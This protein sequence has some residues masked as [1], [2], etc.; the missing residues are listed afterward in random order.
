MATFMVGGIMDGACEIHARLLVWPNESC[1]WMIR[2]LWI[3]GHLKLEV[4]RDNYSLV[5]GDLVEL[6]QQAL[7]YCS[8]QTEQ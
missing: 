5:S 8:K 3:I 6:C 7:A 1:S 4:D 2:P